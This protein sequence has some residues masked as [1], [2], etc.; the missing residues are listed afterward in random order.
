LAVAEQCGLSTEFVAYARASLLHYARWMA[1]HETFYLDRPEQLEYPTET[2]AAQE[3]RKANIL[4]AAAHLADDREAGKFRT[5][6][7]WFYDRLTTL[8]VFPTW[9][10]TRPT[11]LLSSLIVLGTLCRR[12]VFPS[13]ISNVNPCNHRRRDRFVPQKEAVRGAVCDRCHDCSRCW[14]ARVAWRWRTIE[15]T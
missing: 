7:Q 5:K 6:A 4:T 13:T 12:G 3:I 2:W 11:V 15:T 9:H 14:L 10:Y 1:E 8:M